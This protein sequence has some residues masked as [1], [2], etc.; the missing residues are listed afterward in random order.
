M[1]SDENFWFKNILK[2]R[3]RLQNVILKSNWISIKQVYIYDK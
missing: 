1:F 3:W 2:I